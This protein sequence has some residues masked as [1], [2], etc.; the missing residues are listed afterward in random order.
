MCVLSASARILQNPFR[1]FQTLFHLQRRCIAQHMDE[2]KI[3]S[4]LIKRSA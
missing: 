2:D 4:D 3:D 1:L